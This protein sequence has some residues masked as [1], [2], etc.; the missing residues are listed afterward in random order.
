VFEFDYQDYEDEQQ[1]ERLQRRLVSAR[2]DTNTAKELVAEG[3][4][5]QAVVDR[6]QALEDEIADELGVLT[7]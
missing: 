7:P 3:K 1:L 6:Q 5:P 4:L 2:K